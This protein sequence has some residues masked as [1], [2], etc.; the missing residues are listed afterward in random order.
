MFLVLR[1]TTFFVYLPFSYFQILDL[2]Y[3]TVLIFYFDLFWM[4][5]H[6]KPAII[7]SSST[8]DVCACRKAD[9]THVCQ[10][11]T[12]SWKLRWLNTVFARALANAVQRAHKYC[13]K[14]NIASIQ[15]S[16][17]LL[18]VRAICTIFLHNEHNVLMVLLFY[19]KGMLEK[20]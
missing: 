11:P 10:L 2:I 19:C 17:Y 20:V 12:V 1:G 5:W 15:R 4:A 13:I 14:T 9:M 18:N 16:F 6:W 7:L 8:Q 3:W